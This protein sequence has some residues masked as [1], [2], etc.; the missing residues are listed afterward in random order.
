MP[1]AVP[2]YIVSGGN[3]IQ[4]VRDYTWRT[5]FTS[6]SHE[7]DKG[8]RVAL[9]VYVSESIGPPGRVTVNEAVGIV[10][11]G[12][13]NE[14]T[15]SD[16]CLDMEQGRLGVSILVK[17]KSVVAWSHAVC[18]TDPNWGETSPMR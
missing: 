3:G 5:A 14:D 2:L 18:K 12:T 7:W 8:E 10:T 17:H 6:P 4:G 9:L 13:V 1:N 15:V 16:S 11:C